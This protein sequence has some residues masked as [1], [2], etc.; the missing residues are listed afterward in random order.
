MRFG[1]AAA[2]FAGFVWNSR[3]PSRVKFFC[4]L[5]VQR[6]IHTRDVL[7]KKHIVEP[8]GA[9]CPVCTNRTSW[10]RLTIW[11]SPVRLRLPSGERLGCQLLARMS[12]PWIVWRLRRA[13]SSVLLPS[14]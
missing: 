12:G 2:G 4:W 9:G 5:L 6:R 7:L 1:G 11:L 10:K 8:S 13:W 14:L 3:A